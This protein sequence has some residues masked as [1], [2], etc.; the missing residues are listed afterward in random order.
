MTASERQRRRRSARQ[1]GAVVVFGL[2]AAFMLVALIFLVVG[3]GFSVR[4]KETL[5]DAADSGAFYTA[6]L[7]ARAMN[8]IAL[9]NMVKLAVLAI[10]AALP[11]IILGAERT[12]KWIKDSYYRRIAFGWTIPFLYMIIGQA[13]A[14]YSASIDRIIMLLEAAENGQQTL[15]SD[16][17]E[18][19][20]AQANDLVTTVYGPVVE[21]GFTVPEPDVMMTEDGNVIDM[22][23]RTMPY[24]MRIVKEACDEAH[25]GP[26]KSKCRN[27]SNKRAPLFC[28]AHG[29]ITHVVH[30]EPLGREGWQLRFFVM[31]QPL[32]PPGDKGVRIAAWMRNEDGGRV[33]QL[34][35]DLSRLGFAQAE[36]WFDGF[37]A[38]TSEMMWAMGWKARMRRFRLPQGMGSFEAACGMHTGDGG[39][40][41][42][43]GSHLRA[44][45]DAI[46]H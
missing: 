31:G 9:L 20:E 3:A 6:V 25:A 41:G 32:P 26:V 11:A 42:A 33:V 40:C 4:H 29:V 24:W 7:H 13:A 22:C 17:A 8:L 38:N 45:G 46:I 36:Y 21:A 39:W 5:Q 16:L 30:D 23:L 28:L 27:E 1:R 43:V 44:M 18:I 10:A 15:R 12:I 2:F 37:E 34:R 35:D 14:A 19:A